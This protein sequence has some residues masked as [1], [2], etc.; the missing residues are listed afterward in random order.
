M[1]THYFAC[2]WPMTLGDIWLSLH[3]NACQLKLCF[4]AKGLRYQ[5]LPYEIDGTSVSKARQYFG[6]E[7]LNVFF[8]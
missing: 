4:S 1:A 7:S 3:H 2:L 5:K 6:L 8:I